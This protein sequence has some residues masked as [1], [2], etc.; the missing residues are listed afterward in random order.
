VHRNNHCSPWR[1]SMREAVIVSYARTGM[2]KTHRGVSTTPTRSSWVAMSCRPR[3]ERAGVEAGDVEDV[4]FGSAQPEGATGMNVARNIALWPLAARPRPQVPPSTASAPRACRPS[5]MPHTPSSMKAHL[6]LLAAA[7]KASRWS[8]I[9]ARPTATAS[10]KKAC[11]KK[12]PAVWMS[13][14]ETAEIVADRY[15]VSREYQ[16]EY[17]AEIPEAHRRLPGKRLHG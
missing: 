4:F 12:W 5:P 1:E 6:W 16:D 11:T 8:P 9:P 17:S 3:F 10:W 13:M 14:I 7:S 15:G 2:T